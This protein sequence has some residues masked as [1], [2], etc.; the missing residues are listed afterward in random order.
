[1]KYYLLFFQ[2][3]EGGECVVYGVRVIIKGGFNLLLMM[4]FF[5]GCLVGCNV[6]IFNFFKIKGIYIVIKFGMLV[7]ESIFILLKDEKINEFSLIFNQNFNNSDL[8]EELFK[9]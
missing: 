2:Y 6:G 3:F 8:W 7:V 4:M 5:G 1:M 9:V